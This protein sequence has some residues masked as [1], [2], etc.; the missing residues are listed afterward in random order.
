MSI[1][2]AEQSITAYLSGHASQREQATAVPEFLRLPLRQRYSLLLEQPQ[3]RHQWAGQ[4]NHWAGSAD[5]QYRCLVSSVTDD[6]AT[7]RM[8][9]K[10]TVDV[11]GMPTRLGL[12]SY[13]HY[14][15]VSASAL[16]A[17]HPEVRILYK[18]ATTEL[19]I[20]FGCGARNPLYPSI[21]PSGSSTGSAVAVAAHL[22]DIAL[23]T[24]VLGSVR[25]PAAHCGMVGL[26]MTHKA[27]NLD[28][29]F[30]LSP[31]MDAL[32]WV[33][34][35]A[36]DLDFLMPRLG[37]ERHLG[38]QKPLAGTYRIGVLSHIDDGVTTAPMLAMMDQAKSLLADLGMPQV[39]MQLPELWD[40]RGS[41]WQ[42]CARDAWLA[43]Q[44]WREIFDADLHWSTQAALEV[45][46]G[47][48]DA[49]YQQITARMQAVRA[50]ID[51]CFDAAGVDVVVFPIDPC[52]P[53]DVRRPLPGDSTIPSP[54]DPDYSRKIG[55]TPLASFS[56]LPAITL[57]IMLSADGKAPLALQIMGRRD[58]ELQLID[59]AKRL[60]TL[61]GP[62]PAAALDQ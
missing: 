56:G 36:D 57:P 60:E 18:V 32:G 25:W 33:T 59:L 14:P 30:P 19:N 23:G 43:S 3:L 8:G 35:T 28:G 20:G 16:W 42:L 11:A 51:S 34:R 27:S 61:R 7:F 54:A 62:L 39:P 15:D 37:L 1:R 21:D 40:C 6:T 49:E 48:S 44:V 45:G 17:V 9:V 2:T 12:R 46:A 22:C 5:S 52:R 41:A 31:S 10:D 58:S 47:V 38:V 55:F 29:V 24:D 50:S 4:Y 13:R 26:R 53:F